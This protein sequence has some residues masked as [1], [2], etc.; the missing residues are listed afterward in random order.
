MQ[1]L[2]RNAIADNALF[3][4]D[5]LATGRDRPAALPASR[6][7]N[8]RSGFRGRRRSGSRMKW[9]LCWRVI[10]H[11]HRTVPPT[12]MLEGNRNIFNS[13]DPGAICLTPGHFGQAMRIGPLEEKTSFNVKRRVGP[14]LRQPRKATILEGLSSEGEVAGDRPAVYVGQKLRAVRAT[15]ILRVGTAR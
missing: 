8:T 15:Q 10:L 2:V 9:K 5:A 7:K 4:H 3:A 1:P 11:L 13:R 6:P 12:K 14:R